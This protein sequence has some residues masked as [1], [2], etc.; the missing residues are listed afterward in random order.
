MGE[1]LI[2]MLLKLEEFDSLTKTEFGP[3]VTLLYHFQSFK[4]G[5]YFTG[6]KD[7]PVKNMSRFTA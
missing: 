2:T 7:T 1:G 6:V 4:W 3:A 5:F